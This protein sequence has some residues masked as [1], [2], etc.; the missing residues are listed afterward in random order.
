MLW[1]EK[2]I[3]LV[4]RLQAM[5]VKCDPK[6]IDDLVNE[7]QEVTRAREESQANS[8]GTCIPEYSVLSS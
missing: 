1:L 8:Q 2:V 7:L 3:Q 5:G 4:F 6:L